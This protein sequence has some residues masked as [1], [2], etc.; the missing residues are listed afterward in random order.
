MSFFAALFVFAFALNIFW[1]NV[2]APLYT[3]FKGSAITKRLLIFMALKDA[4]VIC[5]LFFIA[6]NFVPANQMLVAFV[7]MA[8][9][10]AITIEKHALA[11]G[12]WHYKARM[13]LIPLLQTGVS[14]TVQ[15]ATTGLLAYGAVSVILG[16][17]LQ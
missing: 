15:L 7:I 1:E 6:K 4:L 3:D 12:R 8:V 13:S 11:T 10:F 5:L 16:T 17:M 14:P 2:H 9:L